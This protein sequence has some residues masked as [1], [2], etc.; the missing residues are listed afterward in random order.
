MAHCLDQSTCA[1]PQGW[2]QSEIFSQWFLHFIKH[3][4]LTK[5][6][7]VILV[8]DRHYSHTR[9]LEV[10]TLAREN[11]VDIMCFPPHST[12]KMQPLDKDF[13]RSLKTFYCQEIEKWL[14][15]HPGRVLTIYQNGELF[16]NAYKGAATGKIAANGFRA[17]F[18]VTRISSYHMISLCPQRTKMLLL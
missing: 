2:I 1:V 16:G 10:I 7:T 5:E 15:S 18:F 4:K 12:H 13:M 11:H 17:S 8:M 3:T 9:N 6:D 14:R